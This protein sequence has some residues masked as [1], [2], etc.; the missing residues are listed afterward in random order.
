MSPRIR[1]PL[2][3]V[4]LFVCSLCGFLAAL[5][6]P[7]P[8]LAPLALIG[9]A[10]LVLLISGS[11]PGRAFGC[12][13]VFGA[14][15][16]GVLIHWLVD[17]FTVYGHMSYYLAIP[18][19]LVPVLYKA[20]YIGLFTLGLGLSERYLSVK[21]GSPAWILTGSALFT[22]LEHFKGFFLGGLPWEPL[23]S[24]LTGIPVLIQPADIVG[25]GGL[26]FLVMTV[27]MALAAGIVHVRQKNPARAAA[28]AGLMVLIP[29]LMWG[30]GHY[31]LLD[32]DGLV[33]KAEI[34]KAALVQ[35]SIDQSIKWNQSAIF[36]TVKV[37][38]DLTIA[39]AGEKPWLTVWPETAM[40]FAYGRHR[41]LTMR[42]QKLARELN[43]ALLFGAAAWEIQDREKVFF[44]RAN[45]VGPDGKDLGHYDKVR[46][47][48]FG[49]YVPLRRVFP[50][51][52]KL[53]RAFGRY[54]PGKPGS[55][56][57]LSG[58]GLGVSICYESV[59]PDLARGQTAAGADCLII[60][61]NDSWFGYSSAVYQH[62]DQAILRAVENRRSVV[63][64][65]NTG[66][67]GFI[68]P[69][70]EYRSSLKLFEKGWQTGSIPLMK[71]KT[72]YTRI[73]DV[74]PWTCL[75]AVVLIFFAALIKR[76]SSGV[77]NG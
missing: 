42:L 69:T 59:Y 35:A 47:V 45:L 3:P 66:R 74:I 37:Y 54:V 18:A 9:Y 22:G 29:A 48:P 53:S 77:G 4:H 31:R 24:A 50:F 71:F 21:P 40:P 68:L 44:N 65:A 39:A 10:P 43:Q 8:Q 61:T 7:K 5:A 64:A 23:G 49:E 6:F 32:L 28:S 56:L 60:I 55:L 72:V 76:K 67:S 41:V 2:P 52:G 51:M 33:K 62:F 27:N 75:A 16:F 58:V 70:G 13:L 25:T 34:K 36:S 38:S 15:Q 26:T 46:L 73:G 11:G 20:L 14:V 63:R 12:G 57:E 30:Y 17:V 19:Y 1:S